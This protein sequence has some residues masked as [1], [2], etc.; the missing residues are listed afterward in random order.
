MN[1]IVCIKQVP[2]SEAQV[3][4]AS[5]GKALDLDQVK[6]V[7][8]PY[9]EFAVEEAIRIKE[10][11]GDGT[12]TVVSLGPP[13]VKDALRSALAMGADQAV[14]LW[15]PAFEGLDSHGTAVLLSRY[16]A[17]Q[18]YDLIL[19]GKQAI[20]DDM[21]YIGPALADL[22]K[23]PLVSVVTKLEFSPDYKTAFA[24]REGERGVEKI[25]VSLPAVLTA[26]KGLNEPRY[27][28]LMGIM[29]AKKKEIQEVNA[30]ALGMEGSGTSDLVKSRVTKLDYP[31]KRPPGK[32]V[33]G[34]AAT[35]AKE[36]V[37]L[38]REEAKII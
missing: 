38:L 7:L 2:D 12:V 33:P 30:A 15:D 29:K 5:D 20:D 28:S 9:D 25:E 31:P 23:L 16:L 19:L 32:I 37:R 14:L 21:S 3:K 4:I 1:I 8:N 36:L 18:T 13:R 11:K 27:A 17:G 6:F 24:Q 26:Q 34:D 10:K 22:L 35:A